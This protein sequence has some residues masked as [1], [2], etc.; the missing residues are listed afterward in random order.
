MNAT[1]PAPVLVF[2]H[3]TKRPRRQAQTTLPPIAQKAIRLSELDDF[4]ARTVERL[5]DKLIRDFSE[6]PEGA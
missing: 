3:P 6:L 5:L 1:T 2:R 4:A